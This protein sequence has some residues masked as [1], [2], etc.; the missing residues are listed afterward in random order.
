MSPS[1]SAQLTHTVG[2]WQAGLQ[3]RAAAG[4]QHRRAGRRQHPAPA[5]GRQ[6]QPASQPRMWTVDGAVGWAEL[7]LLLLPFL[8]VHIQ[9]C[10]GP[11]LL[12]EGLRIT[13]NTTTYCYAVTP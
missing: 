10:W 1:R 12:C 9:L 8:G 2:W 7:L 13:R 5:P 6:G 11:D 3:G 4:R